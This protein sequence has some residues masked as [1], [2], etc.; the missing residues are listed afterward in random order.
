MFVQQGFTLICYML[1]YGCFLCGIKIQKHDNLP[2]HVNENQS[3]KVTHNV[4][5]KFIVVAPMMI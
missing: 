5:V 3:V 2:T 4:E 1:S